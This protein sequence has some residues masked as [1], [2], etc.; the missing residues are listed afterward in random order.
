MLHN[1][2]LYKVETSNNFDR[3]FCKQNERIKRY[4]LARI[5]TCQTQGI[6]G[7]IK[8]LGSKLYEMRWKNGIRV[9]FTFK[10]E[11]IIFLLTGGKKNDQKKD[12]KKAREIQKNWNP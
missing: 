6:L 12:I 3:W 1:N 7:D 9:Y 10:E 8:M 11:N 4:V 5:L 2:M